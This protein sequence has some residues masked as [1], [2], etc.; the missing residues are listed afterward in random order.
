MRRPSLL[1]VLILAVGLVG[2]A[3][4]LR[5][6]EGNTQFVSQ[7]QDLLPVNAIALE[8]LILTTSDPRPGY[9]GRAQDARCLTA[10][11]TA[12]RTGQPVDLCGALS[13]ASP[14]ALRGDRPRRP[15]DLW[16]PAGLW[17]PA[18]GLRRERR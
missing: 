8:R 5:S 13:T 11:A 9:G 10:T 18:W 2:A 3:V 4:A 12:S 15:F 17:A 16:A 6:R 7:Q 1:L 14:C